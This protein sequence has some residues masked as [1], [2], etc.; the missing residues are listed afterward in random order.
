MTMMINKNHLLTASRVCF[1]LLGFSAI[2]TEIATLNERGKFIPANFFS[3]FTVESNLFAVIILLLSALSVVNNR[4]SERI[5]LLRGS[6]TLNMI[7]VGVVF[8]LLLAGLDG[9]LTAV[10]WDNSVLHYI[11]PVVVAL[12]W[13]FDLPNVR[14]PFRRALIW[15]AFPIAYVTYSLIR[16]Y[17]A[18]WY[19]YSFLNPAER[20]YIGVTITSLVIAFVAAGLIW[21]LVGFTG[22]NSIKITK[23]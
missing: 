17:F 18:N 8:S 16:G 13:F 10:R 3:Y 2:V 19:P 22:R 14:I 23:I 4:R 1:A 9:E 20:G 11:M 12:D 6:S 5:A 7:V 21:V 15:M